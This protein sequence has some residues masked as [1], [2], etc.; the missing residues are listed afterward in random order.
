MGSSRILAALGLSVCAFAANA[1]TFKLMSPDFGPDKPF[2]D[3]FTFKGLGCS[4]ANV[5]PALN[6]RTRRPATRALP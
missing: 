5:S 1:Q 6:W 4:G 3:R 2:D